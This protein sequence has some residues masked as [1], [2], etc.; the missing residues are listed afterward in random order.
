MA[1]LVSATGC[2]I[3][4]HDELTTDEGTSSRSFD[5]R[6]SPVRDRHGRLSGRIIVFRDS[7]ERKHVAAALRRQNEEL[8]ALAHEN[9]Q[10]YTAV[11]QELAERKQAEASLYQAK[12]AAEVANRAKSRFLANMSHELRTPLSAILGHADLLQLQTTRRVYTNT[13]RRYRA[14]P[15]G[16]TTSARSDQRYPRS[17]TDRG[18]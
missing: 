18:E 11:Q 16:R 3:E 10:L 13:R 4:A 5:L 8:A 14:N 6:I 15:A 12:E 7:T 1:E 17:H 9:A 2:Y